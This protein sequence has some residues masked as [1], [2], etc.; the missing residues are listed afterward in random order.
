MGGEDFSQYSLA[1]V[2]CCMLRLGTIDPNLFEKEKKGEGVVPSLHSPQYAPVPE[3][4]IKTGVEAMTAAIL[5][6]VG[7]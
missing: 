4:S 5:R 7:K 2:P 6:I 3:P 1:G